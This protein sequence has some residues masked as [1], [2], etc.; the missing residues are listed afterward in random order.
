MTARDATA[1]VPYGST[2]SLRLRVFA[3]LLLIALAV[4]CRRR[5]A[6]TGP[7][8]P[9]DPRRH[10]WVHFVHDVTVTGVNHPLALGDRELVGATVVADGNAGA[11]PI[12]ESED[13]DVSVPIAFDPAHAFADHTVKLALRLP[14][15]CGTPVELPLEYTSTF[16]SPAE[17]RAD[18]SDKVTLRRAASNA[19]TASG[20]TVWVDD[21]RDPRA[22]ITFGKVEIT[23]RMRD[24][25]THAELPGRKIRLWDLTCAPEHTIEVDGKILGVAKPKGPSDTAFLVSLAPGTCYEKRVAQY[26]GAYRPT[27]APDSVEYVPAAPVSEVG[28]GT[29]DYFL[30]RTPAGSNVTSLRGIDDVPCDDTRARGR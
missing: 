15:P 22:K 17:E 18:S 5:S 6:P 26:V 19:T 24:E 9:P 25:K 2:M 23:G 8:V 4:A 27:A 1:A 10:V 11:I 3:L 7:P 21:R 16:A 20:F 12:E 30:T 14:S 13:G 28:W 29:L